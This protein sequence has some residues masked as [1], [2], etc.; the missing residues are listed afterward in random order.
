MAI[1]NRAKGAVRSPGW[2]AR[3]KLRPAHVFGGPSEAARIIYRAGWDGSPAGLLPVSRYGQELVE[4]LSQRKIN[5]VCLTWSPGFSLD[6]DVAQWELVGRLLP[7]LKKKRIRPIAEISLTGCYANEMFARVPEAKGWLD[8]HEDRTPIAHHNKDCLQMNIKNEAWRQYLAQKVRMAAGAGFDG[9]YFSDALSQAAD[10][11][12][13]VSELAALARSCRPPDADDLL[14]Y[15][16]TWRAEPLA[17]T[18]NFKFAQSAAT[19]AFDPAGTISS[20]LP[21]W[22]VLFELGGREK[23]FACAF[24][25]NLNGKES[26]LAAAEALA[27]GGVPNDPQLPQSYV[28]FMLEHSELFG[29][30]DPVNV[31]GILV[32]EDETHFT[33]I[34]MLARDLGLLAMEQV[35]FD[36][37]PVRSIDNFELRKYKVLSAVHLEKVAPELAEI[38]KKFAASGGTVLCSA[39]S[40]LGIQAP[41]DS[42]IAGDARATTTLGKGR[43]IKYSLGLKDGNLTPDLFRLWVEDLHKFGG[44]QPVS[45][46]APKGLLAVLWGKGTRRWVHLLNFRNESCN[47]TVQL[48]GCGGRK[49]QVHSPDVAKPQLNILETGSA[50]AKFEVKSIETYTVVAVD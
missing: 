44:E 24:C 20:N 46:E 40:D 36:T 25:D 30:S 7:L 45:V 5:C 34:G 11:A 39:D 19:P 23:N 32:G 21:E 14:I 37:I 12:N 35:Q 10:T 1:T 15:T 3:G 2:A 13:L 31:V 27:A 41:S 22:K 9:F 26:A 18:A 38:L 17:D 49:I 42:Y 50:T 29:A 6:G 43:A 33:R 48:P 8:R 47:A 4:E 28:D 16:G